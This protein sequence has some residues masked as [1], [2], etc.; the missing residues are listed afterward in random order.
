MA[1]EFPCPSCGRTLRAEE[2][3]QERPTRCP[4]CGGDAV[5]PAVAEAVPEAAEAIQAEPLALAQWAVRTDRAPDPNACPVCG[6]AMAARAVLCIECG[7]DRRTGRTRTVQVHRYD[8]YWNTGVPSVGRIVGLGAWAVILSIV[9]IAGL[10]DYDLHPAFLALGFLVIVVVVL[11]NLGTFNLLRIVRAKSGRLA[12]TRD[13]YVAFIP[14]GKRTVFLDE[15]EIVRLDE[16]TGLTSLPVF[17]WIST[18]VIG[19]SCYVAALVS[20]GLLV[21]SVRQ[22]HRLAFLCG[23]FP[24]AIWYAY[25]SSQVHMVVR[26]VAKRQRDSIVLY[27]GTDDG[28]MRDIVEGLKEA[29]D[30]PL[31][32]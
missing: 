26:L 15:C 27:R 16:A 14:L 8:R 3:Y 29:A 21:S 30:L 7:F 19:L 1:I 2:Q 5:I 4:A 32:R 20:L 10:L 12:L 6:T 23:F 13:R 25:Q 11:A 22:A 18:L 31:K 28:I 17:T 24:A 9:S